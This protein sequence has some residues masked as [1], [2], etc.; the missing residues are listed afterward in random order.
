VLVSRPGGGRGN[1]FHLDHGRA[2]RDV[3]RDGR[4]GDGGTGG[5]GSGGTGRCI[6]AW[7]IHR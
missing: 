7:D 6:W 4:K 2:G 5:K 3:G 1:E